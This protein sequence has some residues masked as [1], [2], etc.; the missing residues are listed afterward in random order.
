MK[1]PTI[2][3]L[4]HHTSALKDN[5]AHREAK[6]TTYCQVV[7]YLLETYLA[8]DVIAKGQNKHHELQATR[9]YVCSSQL[10]TL[11][12]KAL[13]S[14]LVYREPYLKTVLIEGLHHSIFFSM[15]DHWGTN[16]E[17]TI[18]NFVRF[19]TSLLK[20]QVDRNESSIIRQ[21]GIFSLQKPLKKKNRGNSLALVM[22]IAAKRNTKS[23]L[24]S[25]KTP[26]K[27]LS[28]SKH[29]TQIPKMS[30]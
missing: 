24:S 18:R 13:T 2:T 8:G 14:G 10:R 6:F 15:R 5:D 12:K 17:T 27:Y 22:P 29:E 23:S 19:I 26:S 28:C 30:M 4:S 9:K 11:R 3:A 16:R 21:A 1:E 25:D 20:L 7:S